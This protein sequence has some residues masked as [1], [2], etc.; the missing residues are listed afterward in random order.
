[1]AI[2]KHLLDA[3][4]ELVRVIEGRFPRTIE[5]IAFSDD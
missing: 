4:R 2:D 3:G 1:V 5:H